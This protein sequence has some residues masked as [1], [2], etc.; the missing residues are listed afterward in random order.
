MKT[1]KCEENARKGTGTGVC[2][3]PLDKNGRC[4]RAAD[5]LTDGK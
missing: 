4:D 3:R 2:D 1:K 5:H